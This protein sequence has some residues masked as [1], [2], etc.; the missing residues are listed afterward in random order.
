MDKNIDVI[1]AKDIDAT[2]DECRLN[3]DLL[4]KHAAATADPQAK[5]QD[6]KLAKEWLT[7][8]TELENDLA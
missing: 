4:N 1:D 7:K 6:E 8:A 2:A 5:S 3:A